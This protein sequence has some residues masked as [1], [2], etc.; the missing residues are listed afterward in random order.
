MLLH[1][2]M[3]HR[4][5]WRLQRP[6][7]SD[8]RLISI[9]LRGHGESVRRGDS[10]SVEQLAQDVTAL[11]EELE[12]VDAVGIGW[13]LGASVLWHV[14]TGPAAARFSGSVIIDMTPKV[15]NGEDWQLGLSRDLCEARTAGIHNEFK[16]FAANAGQAMF[17][18]P[19]DPAAREL[20]AWAAQEFAGNDQRSI[21]SLWESLVK[22]DLRP[23]LARIEQPTLIVH[24][25]Q[26]QLYGSD[27]AQ[28]LAEALPNGKRVPF[29]HSGHAPHIEQ[30][31]LF[32]TAIHQFAATLPN[33]RPAQASH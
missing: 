3:A 8:F 19:T 21:A 24:G 5:F 13:S 6:L 10:P 9:D 4:G 15:Q 11:V 26:S 12:L 31:E 14:L 32:N 22:Q 33:V 23:L 18:Q 17:A 25:A 29:E 28:Y 7:A 20:A 2:L 16:A 27:T 30:P 1:G